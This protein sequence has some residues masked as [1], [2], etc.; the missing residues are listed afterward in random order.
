YH[1]VNDVVGDSRAGNRVQPEGPASL[2]VVELDQ[3]LLLERFQKL[4]HKER[5]S[6]R[7]LQDETRERLDLRQ[8]AVKRIAD[9]E[10]EII[11]HERPDRQSLDSG[12]FCFQGVKR[13]NQR[14]RG[15]HL[16]VTISADQEKA[17][18]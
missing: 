11:E 8:I 18:S 15:I 2:G 10:R 3:S 4:N 17:L 14:V 7:L 5:V 13:S 6:A 9:K 12:L 1:E 16:V